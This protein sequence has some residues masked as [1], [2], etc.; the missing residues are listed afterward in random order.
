MSSNGEGRDQTDTATPE[1]A[2]TNDRVMGDTR[3]ESRAPTVARLADLAILFCATIGAVALGL[4]ISDYLIEHSYVLGYLVA[5]A[6]FRISD[7][8]LRADSEAARDRETA[9][10]RWIGEVPILLLFAAAPFERTYLYGGETPEGIA[11]TGLLLELIGLWI[12]IGARVQLRFGA[13]EHRVVRGG[14]Y[15]FVRHP[16]RA[17][18]LLVLIA[19]PL[20]FGAPIVA[21]ATLVIVLIASARRMHEEEAELLLR[22]GEEYEAYIQQTDRLIPNVW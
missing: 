15:R 10:P 2:S 20:E 4:G 11:A 3:R 18:S 8:I 13:R 9:M 21:L 6:G 7:T 1:L 19:W 17:G 12:A 22:F 16:V 14:F 5:Y